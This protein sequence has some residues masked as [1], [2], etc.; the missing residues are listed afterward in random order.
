[1][2]VQIFVSQTQ[3]INP[4]RHKILNRVLDGF[5]IPIIHEACAELLENSGP[6]LY[7]S[8]YQAAGIRRDI[9]AVEMCHHFSTTQCVKFDSFRFTLCHQKGRLSLDISDSSQSL[10]ATRGGLFWSFL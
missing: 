6:L 2:I 10:N 1:M 5:W 9:A 7:F 8:Q 3:S 4:L